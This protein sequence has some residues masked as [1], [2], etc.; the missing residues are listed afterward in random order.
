VNDGCETTLE[1][2]VAVLLGAGPLRPREIVA[3]LRKSGRKASRWD[4]GAMLRR[5]PTVFVQDQDFRWRLVGH[6]GSS[7]QLQLDV[8]EK[9]TEVG[10]EPLF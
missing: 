10:D 8:Q 6:S 7:A 4:I 5:H 2:R 3:E 1:H 9:R